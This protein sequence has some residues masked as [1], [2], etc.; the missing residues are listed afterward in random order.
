M[1]TPRRGRPPVAEP[2]YFRLTVRLTEAEMA[3]LRKAAAAAGQSVSKFAR[4]RLAL[5]TDERTH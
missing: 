2:R 3:E 1:K 4:D 5:D